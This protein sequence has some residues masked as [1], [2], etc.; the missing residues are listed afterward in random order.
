VRVLVVEDQPDMLDYLKRVL[1]EQG[2]EVITAGS[3]REAVE[4]L[5][6]PDAQ[7][8]VLV[9]DIGMPE[10]SGYQLLRTLRQQCGFSAERLPAIAVTAFAREEDRARAFAAGFQGY[11]TKPYEVANL[12][13]LVRRLGT[14]RPGLA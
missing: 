9:S 1:E 6:S 8:L 3:G 2:A 12:I 14:A 13:T 11:L 5:S 4:H 7:P 10:M